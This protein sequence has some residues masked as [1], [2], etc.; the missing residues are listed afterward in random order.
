[1]SISQVGRPCIEIKKAYFWMFFFKTKP[2]QDLIFI[3][4]NLCSNE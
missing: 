3:F 2:L 4:A 1:M